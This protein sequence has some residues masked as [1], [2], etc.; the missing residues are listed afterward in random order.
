MRTLPIRTLASTLGTVVLGLSLGLVLFAPAAQAK[1]RVA[2]TLPDL[3]SIAKE[4]GKEHVDVTALASPRQDPHYVDPRPSLLVALSRADLVVVNG[5]QLEQSWLQPLLVQARNADIQVG[6][7]GYVDASTFVALLQVPQ[8]QI[9]R[10]M[11]D[12]HP[13]GNPHFTF[14]PRRAA[15]IAA[16]LAERM[17]RLDP[18]H[19]QAYRENA[20]AFADDMSALATEARAR[21]A[22]LTPKQRRVVSYHLSLVYLWDWLAIEELI[23]VEPKPGIPPDP[24]H[25]AKVLKLMKAQGVSAIVQEEFYPTNVSETLMKLTGAKA[26]TVILEG[27][28]RFDEG[29]SY[30]THIE[31]ILEVLHAALAQQAA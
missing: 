4:V 14:D 20:K 1:L 12:I 26:K 8:M 25:V 15:Q 7:P 3:A 16:G 31:N 17:A 30:R 19:T 22:R 6:A 2:A 21:F 29:Q 27:G 13:G 11:G 5:L 9:S 23:N 24:A 10:A 18:D 28:T